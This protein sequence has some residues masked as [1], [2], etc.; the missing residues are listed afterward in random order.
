MNRLSDPP[1]VFTADLRAGAGGAACLRRG[2]ADPEPHGTWTIGR[3]S[4][5]AIDWAAPWRAATLTVRATP[6]LFAGLAAAR[7]VVLVN[8]IPLAAATVAAETAITGEIARWMIGANHTLE[9]TLQHPDAARPAAP[10]SDARTL[11]FLISAVDLR[12][13]TLPGT[14][15]AS[16]PAP[17]TAAA[18]AAVLRRFTSLGDNWEFALVQRRCGIEQ[19]SL[20]GFAG[21]PLAG[22]IAGLE[23][24]FAGLDDPDAIAAMLLPR[25]WIAGPRQYLI[26]HI[27]YGAAWSA[28]AFEGEQPAERILADERRKLGDLKRELL[29]EL[30]ATPRI[31]VVRRARPLDRDSVLPLWRA[32]R[33]HGPHAL[34]WVVPAD[35][36]RRAGT[37]VVHAPGLFQGFIDHLAPDADPSDVSP[38]GWV[39]L[40]RRT[41]ALRDAG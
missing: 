7:L 28:A 17:A 36:R 15:A 21:A 19:A 11:G 38:R 5:L 37:V 12:A 27:D 40:C 35:A 3:E 24:D 41:V 2:W 34:L 39:E 32:L 1:V 16:G 30:A 33:R 4:R 26:Y 22:V 25:H 23:N 9:I 31:Y 10:S 29:Q 14:P 6:H 18:E 13:H 8:G 20:F